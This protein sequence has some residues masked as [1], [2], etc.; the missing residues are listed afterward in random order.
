MH[1]L[2]ASEPIGANNGA[3]QRFVSVGVVYLQHVAA[4]FLLGLV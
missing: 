3:P 4:K 2:M 1:K